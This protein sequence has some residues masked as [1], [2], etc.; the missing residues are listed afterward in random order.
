MNY[1]DDVFAESPFIKHEGTAPFQSY[2]AMNLPALPFQA[3]RLN[4]ESY[5][6]P[7]EKLL[8][9]DDAHITVVT[10]P[11]FEKILKKHMTIQE[12]NDIAEKMG[13]QKTPYKPLCIGTGRVSIDGDEQRTYYV[14][15]EASGLFKI[16]KA[17][18]DLYISRGGKAKDFDVDLFF[19]HVTLGYTK[20]D[21]HYEDGV[22]KDATSCKV[23]LVKSPSP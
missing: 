18:L 11:E 10:P 23:T 1:S 9:R 12:I 8:H 16:R 21:L 5:L 2:L 22:V 6:P 17:I 15:M 13:I 3:L 14:V 4:L 7:K 20:R 19:P